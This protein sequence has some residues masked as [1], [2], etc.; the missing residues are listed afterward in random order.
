MKTFADFGIDLGGKHGEEVKVTCPHCS[1][2][3]K[4]KG[5]P[6]LNVNTIKG[7][8]NCWHCGWAGGLSQGEYTRPTLQKQKTFVK[9]EFK[10]ATLSDAAF[11]WFKSRGITVDVLIRNRIS[12]SRVWMPQIE[13]EVTAVA[14]PYLRAGEVVN[15][16]FRDGSKN[17]RQ[18][19]GA[20]KI[21]YKVDDIAP[22][23]IICEGEM[24]ALSLE[25]AG[26]QNTVS[27]PDGAP[28]PKSKNFET[29]FE[30]LDE[31]T[32]ANVE[33]FI[34]AVDNDEPGKRLEDELSRR[35]GRERCRRVSWPE[36]CKDANEVLM[37]HGAAVL[38]ECIESASPYPIEGVFSIADIEDDI[39]AL[40]DYGLP[41]GEP[42]GWKNLDDLYKPAPG[43]WTL[44]TGIPSHGKSEWLDAM[45]INIAENA[46]WAFAVCSPENQPIAWHTAKLMEKV[47]GERIVPGRVNRDKFDKAKRWLA[48]HYH[49][50]MPEQPTLE[51]VLERTRQLVR[52]KGVRGLII[53]PYNEIDHAKR[54]DGV[55]E[56]EYVSSFLTELRTFARNESIHVWLVAHPQKLMK[57]KN[58]SYPVPDGYTVAGSA[59][60][61]NKADNIIA[62]YRD[63]EDPLSPTEVHVQKVRSRWL[64][65]RGVA[66][67]VWQSNSGRFKDYVAPTRHYGPSHEEQ[68]AA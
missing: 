68:E 38:K 26:F 45:T 8:W 5:Y 48:D 39:N 55:S 64:G 21:L 42:T 3:R 41:Q 10:P 53:D 37:T 16:K 59:H 28:S 32:L 12:M 35:L 19:A 2:T 27:V 65:K 60:F 47:M 36:G 43:Q 40:L 11:E 23:T 58:G 25:V 57:E 15:C 20:E 33:T 66:K 18:V 4:K 49:F 67:L 52:T 46:G 63:P 62:I 7:A 22:V 31:P 51:A 9:P 30:F 54:K 34:L 56:T 29:K 61:Y 6:C 1:H 17:F 24:D 14:F 50:I 13:D 44:V